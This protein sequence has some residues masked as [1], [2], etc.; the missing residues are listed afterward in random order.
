MI[1]IIGVLVL[2]LAVLMAVVGV[3]TNYDGAHPL[4]GDFAIFGQHITGLTTG[5]LLLYG[6]I[7]GL[8]AALGLSILRR[9]LTRN[10]TSRKLQRE[11]KTSRDETAALRVDYEKIIVALNNERLER[12]V[13]SSTSI[14]E[15]TEINTREQE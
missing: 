5:K 9:A 2:L 11:L 6:I 12:K 10:M 8:F 1:I 4:N 13:P 14:T 3:G 7:L 15:S